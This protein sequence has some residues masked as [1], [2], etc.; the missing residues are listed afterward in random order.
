[1][2][3]VTVPGFPTT[4]SCCHLRSILPMCSTASSKSMAGGGWHSLYRMNT[5]IKL[6]VVT[7]YTTLTLPWKIQMI[8]ALK[9]MLSYE[10]SRPI[11]YV[12]T[13]IDYE[14]DIVTS[15]KLFVSRARAMLIAI[16]PSLFVLAIGFPIKN[17]RHCY[18]LKVCKA[19]HVQGT[20]MGAYN[21]CIVYFLWAFRLKN[22][23]WSIPSTFILCMVLMSLSGGL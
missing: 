9:H 20:L 18:R 3:W 12:E 17:I 22:L 11:T 16:I 5:D 21:S 8:A 7:L 14:N 4:S 19:N 10:D 13:I 6:Y 23:E 1:M 15:D 2:S